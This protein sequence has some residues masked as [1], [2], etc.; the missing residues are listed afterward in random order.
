MESAPEFVAFSSTFL[1]VSKYF[2]T[3]KLLRCIQRC[4]RW[5][6]RQSS[7]HSSAAPCGAAQFTSQFTCF[8][9]T[10]EQMLT[11]PE[12]VAFV[13]GAPQFTTQFTCF[14]ST[15]VQI[16][17][18]AR[19]AQAGAGEWGGEGGERGWNAGVRGRVLACAC[20]CNCPRAPPDGVKAH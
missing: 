6:P 14:T 18:Q 10:K 20:A 4:Q 11:P 7:S 1:P 8:V 5:S 2:C 15:K 3:S 12:F 19:R 13:G 9:S 17:T 16:M